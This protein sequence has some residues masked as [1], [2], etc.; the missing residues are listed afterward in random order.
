VRMKMIRRLF[1]RPARRLGRTVI[2]LFIFDIASTVYGY[3]KGWFREP[4]SKA[5][6]EEE[7]IGRC[8]NQP[9]IKRRR[10]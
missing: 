1:L 8:L 3:S 10:W 4:R 7:E 2:N 6:K 5:K 9:G